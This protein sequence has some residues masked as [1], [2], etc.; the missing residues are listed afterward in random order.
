MHQYAFLPEFIQQNAL[1][2]PF[3]SFK[4]GFFNI[5]AESA[6][7]HELALSGASLLCIPNGQQVR[8]HIFSVCIVFALIGH[9]ILFLKGPLVKI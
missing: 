9:I 7:A 1:I 8:S 4:T 3:L 6:R 2:L 5:I